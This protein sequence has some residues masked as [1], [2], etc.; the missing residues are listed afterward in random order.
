MQLSTSGLFHLET[1]QA[2]PALFLVTMHQEIL[3]TVAC[4]RDTLLTKIL[5]SAHRVTCVSAAVLSQVRQLVPE[6]IPH[7]SIIHN[8]LDALP[9]LPAPLPIDPPRLLCLGRLVPQKGFDLALTASAALV[10][11]FPN[12]RLIIAGDGPARPE[13]EQQAAELGLTH[14]VDFRG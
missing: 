3:P 1:H 12:M 11:R 6:I 4:G 14:R 2:H 13:L 5:C 9:L 8:G 7:S 10:D